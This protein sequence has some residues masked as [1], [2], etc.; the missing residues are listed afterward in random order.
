MTWII[1][2]A[3]VVALADEL[4]PASSSWKFF[5]WAMLLMFYWPFYV[6][7][8]IGKRIKRSDDQSGCTGGDD[9]NKNDS[10]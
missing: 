7:L 5:G 2:W 10:V 6:G 8:L 1:G 4:E 9:D 3:I